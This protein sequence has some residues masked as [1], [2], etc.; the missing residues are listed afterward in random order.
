[1][2]AKQGDQLGV[3]SQIEVHPACS[4]NGHAR[5]K[6]NPPTQPSVRNS[7]A[8]LNMNAQA[9]QSRRPGQ[10]GQARQGARNEQTRAD[11]TNV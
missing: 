6:D 4:Q 2:A 5:T 1:M 9:R 8:I 11:A 3:R 10:A 7:N